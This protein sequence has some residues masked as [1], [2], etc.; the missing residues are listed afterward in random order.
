MSISNPQGLPL[1]LYVLKKDKPEVI[2]RIER[3]AELFDCQLV[4]SLAVARCK[5]CCH[6]FI[7]LLD[8]CF[9]DTYA[10]EKCKRRIKGFISDDIIRARVN[11]Q[12]M[13]S[14]LIDLRTQID[15]FVPFDDLPSCRS[16]LDYSPED[17]ALKAID[18][19]ANGIVKVVSRSL[20]I[21]S[22]VIHIKEISDVRKYY[23]DSLRILKS[24]Q[25]QG[26]E[27]SPVE[28][29][30]REKSTMELEYCKLAT[31]KVA[32]ELSSDILEYSRTVI[33]GCRKR[34]NEA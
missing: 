13:L 10:R 34:M 12:K 29:V 14:F 6:R 11:G 15:S 7:A 16:L 24:E 27:P 5:D 22:D 1:G 19:V 33:E 18:L 8:D 26:W 23:L 20:S 32:G 9:Q 28:I 25:E 4:D 30:F 17:S 21:G 2:A 31:L 3:L